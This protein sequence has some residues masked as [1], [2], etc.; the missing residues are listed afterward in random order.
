MAL[1][2][3][4]LSLGTFAQAPAYPA[5]PIRLLVGF[6]PGGAADYVARAM[7][8]SMGKAMGQPMVIENRAGAGSSIAAELAA[9]AA[10]DG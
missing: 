7:S 2:L 4:G 6:A 9:K 8:D 1:L 5:K 3:G 10:P